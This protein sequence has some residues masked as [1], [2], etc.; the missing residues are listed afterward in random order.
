[1]LVRAAEQ[2]CVYSCLPVQDRLYSEL[3]S[4]YSPK[5][6]CH[7]QRMTIEN[8]WQIYIWEVKFFFSFVFHCSKGVC[9]NQMVYDW[10]FISLALVLFAQKLEQPCCNSPWLHGFPDIWWS[11]SKAPEVHSQTWQVSTLKLI[12]KPGR[13]KERALFSWISFSHDFC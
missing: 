3:S 9:L 11:E 10:S 12:H 2:C 6:V 4:V 7:S 13:L 5:Y 8:L 1:M